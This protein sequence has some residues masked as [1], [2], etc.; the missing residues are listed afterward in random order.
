VGEEENDQAEKKEDIEEKRRGGEDDD[1]DE[2]VVSSAP[3]SPLRAPYMPDELIHTHDTPY[4]EAFDRAEAKYNE[5]TG[6]LLPM[7]TPLIINSPASCCKVPFTITR[8]DL[9]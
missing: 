8:N 1:D 6:L 4:E 3:S 2:D 7:S 9:H 5:K